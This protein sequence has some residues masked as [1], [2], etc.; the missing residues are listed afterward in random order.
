M[1]PESRFHFYVTMLTIAVMYLVIQHLFPMLHLNKAVD[2][3]LKPISAIV[4]SAGLYKLFASLLLSSFRRFLWV[5]RFILGANYLNGT[6]IGKFRLGD[7]STVFTVEHFEQTLSS[8]VI[9]GQ[10]FYTSGESYAQWHSVSVSLDET[11][12]RLMYAYNCDKSDDK[13]SFQ[14]IGVFQFERESETRYPEK[15]RGYSADLVDGSRCEN[16]ETKISE[17]LMSFDDAILK[18][19]Q[20]Q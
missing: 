8:L 14:G 15:I 5:K 19:K 20:L 2:P 4:L 1:K 7:S 13:G 17:T 3:Y 16:T 10:A 12:G 9:R 18:A 6:W 11:V